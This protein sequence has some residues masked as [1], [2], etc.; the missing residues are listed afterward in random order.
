MLKNI[1]RETRKAQLP[2]GSLTNTKMATS[3]VQ[4]TVRVPDSE[5]QKDTANA[6]KFVGESGDW[7]NHDANRYYT[8]PATP[9]R[10]PSAAAK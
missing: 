5:L 2:T 6:R 8:N 4:N 7:F 1:W 10:C 9:E 3:K